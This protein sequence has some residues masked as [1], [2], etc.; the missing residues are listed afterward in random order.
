MTNQ[1]GRLLIF[2]GDGKGKTTA[3]LGMALR[4]SGQGMRVKIIQFI[5]ADQSTGEV[6]AVKNLPGV[7]LIQTGLGFVPAQDHPG[8][9]QH[10][11]AA[12]LGMQLAEEAIQSG[13]YDLV[14]LDEVCN[15]VAL[16]LLPEE[17]VAAILKMSG[18]GRIIV[19]TGRDA[20]E[21]LMALADTVTIMNCRKHALE[22][23]RPAQK[24]VEF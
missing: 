19:L 14:I 12:Q 8:F 24:G 6:A 20:S 1:K 3:A 9:P 4:A 17:R 18:P 15:A 10:R 16:H 2:T 23:G 5:K 11:E 21:S 7:E 22:S 13:E